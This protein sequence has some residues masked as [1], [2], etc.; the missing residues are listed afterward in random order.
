MDQEGDTLMI[1][2]SL[3]GATTEELEQA[4]FAVPAGAAN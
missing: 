3:D 2:E 1:T 4:V